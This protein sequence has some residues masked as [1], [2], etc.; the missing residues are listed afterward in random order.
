MFD[1]E[2]LTVYQKTREARKLLYSILRE[3]H[4][5]E[6]S[7]NDQLKRSV[8]GILLNIA[9]GT[10]KA[11]KADKKNFFTIARGSL[12]KLSRSLIF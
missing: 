7:I 1:F 10:G 3:K 8:L 12:M 4:G 9:E 5:T 11:T 2:K 6:K